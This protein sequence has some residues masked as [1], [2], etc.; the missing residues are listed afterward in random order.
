[1]PAHT[2]AIVNSDPALLDLLDDLLT[3]TNYT[4]RTYLTEP[5]TYP[6]LQQLQPDLIILDV[7]M[8][9]SAAGWPL[10]KLLQFDPTT[11]HIPVL[12]ST[13]DH[14]FVRD[15]ADFLESKGYRVLELP[16]SFVTLAGV[17]RDILEPAAGDIKATAG[18]AG[19]L[20]AEVVSEPS[21]HPGPAPLIVKAS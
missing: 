3:E 13:V 19:D 9:A 2:I 6:A 15:K 14:Q 5:A 18:A 11:M 20:P 16:A 17:V 4:V 21:A 1:M 10:L 8:Q 7:G 12:V